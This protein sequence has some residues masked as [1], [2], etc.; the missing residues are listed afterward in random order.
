MKLPTRFERSVW[1]WV[2][3]GTL[4]LP[5]LAAGEEIR[6]LFVPSQ[7]PITQ[8]RAK[9][10]E[11]AISDQSHSLRV[12]KDLA[13]ADVLVQIAGYRVEAHKQAGPWRWWEG[14]IRVLPHADAAAKEV[15]QAVR[16]PERFELVIMGEGGGTGMHR[17]V[18][19]LE[20]FLKK[21][22]GHETHKR[23][24]QEI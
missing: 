16:L 2:V 5:V 8:I 23:G 22:L 20:T 15:A 18:R 12:V 17:T 9:A 7:H 24:G 10:L 21:A 4:F 11:E 13:D 3:G 1:S 19:A 6:V 14:R